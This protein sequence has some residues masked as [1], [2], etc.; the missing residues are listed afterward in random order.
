M[1]KTFIIKGINPGIGRVVQLTLVAESAAEAKAKAEEAGL[2]LV[3]VQ[4][5]PD[6]D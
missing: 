3:T 4:P 1:R 2:E 5:A 6:S